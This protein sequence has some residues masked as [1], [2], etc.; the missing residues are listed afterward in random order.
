MVEAD[1]NG[2]LAIEVRGLTKTYGPQVVLRNLDLDLPWG[3][4]LIVFGPNGSGK[5]T[6]IKVLATITRPAQGEVRV[7]G[8]DLKRNPAAIRRNIGLV[9]HQPLLYGD[10]TALEN[11]KFHG[12]MFGVT[13]LEERIQ[14]AAAL[15]GLSSY[16]GRKVS[17]LSHGMQ[18]RLSL[19]RAILH[20]PPILLL[21][22][23][24]TGLDQEALEMLEQLMG[25][26]ER[27]RRTVL[28]ATHS[29]ERGLAL[30]NR[31]AILAGGKIAYHEDRALV[32]EAMFRGTY[33]RFTG[34]A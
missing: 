11:L 1:G 2:P 31:V 21:D 16:L 5:T 6:L 19:A 29:L 18:K 33:G 24:E 13:H 22:E 3:D 23:P 12:R 4:F 17:I 26:G 27:G 7:A 34:V 20:D 25:V 9:T 10:L 28:M 30:G 14:K 32:D 15:M 8:F